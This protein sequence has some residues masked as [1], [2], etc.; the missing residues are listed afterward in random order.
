MKAKVFNTTLALL[1][2]TQGFCF[3]NATGV[4]IL[5]PSTEVHFVKSPMGNLIVVDSKNGRVR[6]NAKDI[7]DL[8]DD[9]GISETAKCNAPVTNNFQQ[10]QDQKNSDNDA[11]QK[12]K[13][14]SKTYS[15][16]ADT[17]LDINNRFGKVTVHTWDKNEFKVDVQIKV[18]ANKPQDTDKLLNSIIIA[19]SKVGQLVS[20]KTNFGKLDDV[21]TR[22]VEIN[23][24][25]FIPV[26]NALSINNKMGDIELADLEGK[27]T[28]NC[29]YGNLIAKTLSNPANKIKV[30]YGDARIASLRAED[31]NIDYGSLV[32]GWADKLNVDM[33]YTSA[34]IGK[35]ST[36]G[37]INVKYSSGVTITNIDKN[38]KSLQV[39]SNYSTITVGLNNAENADFDVT[40]KYG[41]FT[42]DNRPVNMQKSTRVDDKRWNPIQNFK[43]H[44][45]KGD[46]EKMINI[47]S[48]YSSV[49][50][51]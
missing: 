12:I 32:L 27:L 23:Y 31:L 43:G 19:D 38:L 11:D 36:S 10:N 33:A 14:Y 45:G 39:N 2:L 51:D 13:S 35:I 4:N 5:D 6:L 17:K 42:Y 46:V 9:V 21:K 44:L 8:M 34:K 7:D 16:D 29:A 50:F 37:V 48:A 30:T 24:T 41:S 15:A 47:N 3:A 26:K 28:I 40:V 18:A 1:L 25:V 49:R 22:Q 20:F